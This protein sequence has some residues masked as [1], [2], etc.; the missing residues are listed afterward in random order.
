MHR[1][2]IALVTLIGLTAAAFVAGYLFLFSASTDRAAALAPATSAFYVNVYLQPSAGQQMNLSRLIGRLP[3]FA[4]EAS[5]DEK[6][7][8]VV[9]N[10]L[11]GTGIDYLEQVKPWLGDQV[12]IVGW[13]GSEGAAT[14]P[15][16]VIAEVTDPEAARVAIA[17]IVGQGGAQL[18][19][20]TYAGVE[21][22]VS[23]T[24][25]YAFVGDMVVIGENADAIHAVIDVDGGADSLADRADFVATMDGL[26]PDHLAS[27]FI[28][29]AALTDVIGLS[30]QV[31]G[32]STAGA[33]L[34]AEPEGLRLSA[35][36]PFDRDEATP[37]DAAG[38][39]LGGEPSS[40]VEW[41]PPDTIAEA[42]VFG[43]GQT[44]EDAE[45]ALG[46]APEGE[47]IAGA[48]DTIRALAA[49]ALGIDLDAD[50][51]PL[52]D[53]E[54]A[55]AVRGIEGGLPS[56][57]ILLRPSDPA[58]AT[59]AL[60]RVAS[61]L[62]GVGATRTTEEIG[63]EEVTIL[64]LPDTGEVAYAEV[65][66]IVIL[67]FGSDDVA[68]AIEAHA[69]GDSLGTSE[70][71]TATFDVA[72]TRAG[73]EAFVDV[74]AVVDLLGDPIELPDDARDILLQVGTLGITAPSRN[75]QI[76]FHAVLTVDE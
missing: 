23:D 53:R 24:G 54:V 59:D 11:S 32:V 35:S 19:A 38:F 27:A 34:V 43:L 9:Q 39:A 21:L 50:L 44:L 14:A 56:G 20:E 57:Q 3:G 40:L 58:A 2:V 65:D 68:A 66:G 45:A 37:S 62:S 12:A 73:T 70:R 13:P 4:D 60:D 8:Q 64:S 49:F 1:L 33:V 42:V 67:G 29:L 25:A 47:E 51:L 76:E 17:G 28:D 61:A 10:L 36:A 26:Q 41:M 5:L 71:Y 22:Q 30:D 18:S 7:D 52:L 55:V 31:S 75:H 46:V 63:A 48:L 72:G 74:G 15:A 16:A 6:V 69:S